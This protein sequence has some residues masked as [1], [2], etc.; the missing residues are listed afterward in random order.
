VP[1]Q[2]TDGEE[3]CHV[4]AVDNCRVNASIA[5]SRPAAILRPRL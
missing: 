4:D 1:P 3:E 2:R 5:I